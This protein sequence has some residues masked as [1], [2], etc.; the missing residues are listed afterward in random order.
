[1][2]GEIEYLRRASVVRLE[3]EDPGLRVAFREFE[4]ILEVGPPEGVDALGVIA[5]DR[6]VPVDETHK[7]DYLRLD[8][9]RVLVLVDENMGKDGGVVFPEGF[10]LAED[11]V[12]EVEKIIEIH[13]IGGL[14]LLRVEPLDASRSRR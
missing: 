11:P 6:D 4:D 13:G 10:V 3:P 14:L 8:P 7:I 1:M 12:P 2:V 9:V 5:H